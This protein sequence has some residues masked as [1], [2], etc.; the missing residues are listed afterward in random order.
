MKKNNKLLE[1]ISKQH[2]NNIQREF[3]LRN[4]KDITTME[5]LELVNLNNLNN[6]EGARFLND[7]ESHNSNNYLL[8]L[9]NKVG[10]IEDAEYFFVT[11]E[12]RKLSEQN[13]NANK[14]KEKINS[15]KDYLS[16]NT[17]PLGLMAFRIFQKL[18]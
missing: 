1:G 6:L 14:S 11:E 5:E 3:S 17:I 18:V 8:A 9:K 4:K 15:F 7:I 10:R 12:L 13:Q 16:K 2:E